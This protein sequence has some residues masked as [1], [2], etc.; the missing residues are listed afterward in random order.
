VLLHVAATL[1]AAAA[2]AF[3]LHLA[4]VPG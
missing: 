3:D 2:L 4:V 1:I